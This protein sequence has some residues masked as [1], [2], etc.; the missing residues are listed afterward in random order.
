[1]PRPSHLAPAAAAVLLLAGCAASPSA[2]LP[3]TIAPEDPAP[4]AHA[5]AVAPGEPPPFAFGGD[6]N[7]MV[8]EAEI[9]ELVGADVI[10]IDPETGGSVSPVDVLGGITCGW[11]GGDYAFSA[12]LTVIPA[13]GLEDQIAEFSYPG[14]LTCWGQDAAGTGGAC[15]FGR[16]TAGYWL[17][18]LLQVEDG[19]GLLPADGIDAVAALVEQRASEYPSTP[20][21]LPA[22]TWHPLDCT[23]LADALA[24][25]T[26]TDAPGATT[27]QTSGG[28]LGPI[29]LGAEA[30]VGFARCTWSDPPGFTTDLTPGGGW[31]MARLTDAAPIEVEGASAAVLQEHPGGLDRIIATDGVNLAQ[32]TV[33]ESSAPAEAAAFLALVMRVAG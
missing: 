1:M 31:A 7:A 13:G 18:G 24:D 23:A 21:E 33:P 29:P 9:D 22:G 10:R 32:V 25:E 12:V 5:V 20:V 6:C 3:A 28:Y 30:A 15:Y 27:G 26:S 11:G 16:V 8:T 19:S 17:G 2:D 14:G 4:A